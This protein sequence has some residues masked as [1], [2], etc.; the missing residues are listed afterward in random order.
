MEKEI[1]CGIYKITSPTERIY[2][3]QT[4]D[5]YH[6]FMTYQKMYVKNKVK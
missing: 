5:I 4:V 2:I 3:E 1:I 6:R